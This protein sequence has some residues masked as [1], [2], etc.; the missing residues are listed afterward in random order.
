[1]RISDLYKSVAQLGF[2]ETLESDTRFFFAANRALLQVAA[3]R[4]ATR[5]LTI[6]HA[7]IKNRVSVGTFS[8]VQKKSEL[9]FS[10]SGVKSYYFECDGT[11]ECYIEKWN[12]A[13]GTWKVIGLR[14]LAATRTFTSYRGFVRE[15]ADFCDAL[16]RLRFVGEYLYAVRNVALYGE[17]YSAIEAD[18]PAFS[19]YTPYDISALVD[20]F[21]SLE[22]PVLFKRG[23]E[24][25]RLS[26]GYEVE[27]GR[28]ILLPYDADGLYKIQYRH[29]PLTLTQST[30][31]VSNDTT[32]I[33]LDEE[34]CALLPF[35]IASIVWADDE[36]KKAEYY[37]SI[38][39]ERASMLVS[40]SGHRE[41]VHYRT[42]G[43]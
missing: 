25:V 16:V 18:I 17:I 36:P 32:Q 15:D 2:E 24:W 8:P 6:A 31:N 43:W 3:L 26:D 20:D 33:D 4:P 30:G 21:L 22:L 23:G 27:N 9:C 7:P 38:Y 11:G 37:L 13:S 19:S 41:P 40:L 10:A 12:A 39:R 29:R 35:L 28:V 1:M 34:L 42:N 5:S 14:E